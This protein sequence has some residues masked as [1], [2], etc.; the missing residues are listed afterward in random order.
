MERGGREGPDGGLGREI[1]LKKSD[2]EDE[3]GHVKH[4]W[5]KV[6]D[7]IYVHMTILSLI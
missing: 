7:E 6:G 2:G 3:R 5:K 4:H 1:L